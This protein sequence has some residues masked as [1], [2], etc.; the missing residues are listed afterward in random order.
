MMG[1]GWKIGWKE[2]GGLLTNYKRGGGEGFFCFF[3]DF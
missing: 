1:M 2:A 3:L